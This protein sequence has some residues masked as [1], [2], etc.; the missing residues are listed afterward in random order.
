M[1][2]RDL[3]QRAERL[4]AAERAREGGR[5]PDANYAEKGGLGAR[6]DENAK[7]TL[8]LVPFE[9]DGDD[10]LGDVGEGG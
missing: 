2:V 7:R 3:N 8:R 1:Y 10:P 4:E 6:L 5:D 9:G